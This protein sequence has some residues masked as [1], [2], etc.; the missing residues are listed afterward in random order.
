MKKL[1]WSYLIFRSGSSKDFPCLIICGRWARGPLP[2]GPEERA[3]NRTL[4]AVTS[5]IYHSPQKKQ[6]KKEQEGGNHL[7]PCY[8]RTGT[9]APLAAGAVPS[10]RLHRYRYIY[11][12]YMSFLRHKCISYFVFFFFLQRIFISVASVFSPLKRNR[13]ANRLQNTKQNKSPSHKSTLK[14]S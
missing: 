13:W 5:K 6:R 3:M 8:T 2:I 9:A 4:H 7:T 12:L 10:N 14:L 1:G 11:I